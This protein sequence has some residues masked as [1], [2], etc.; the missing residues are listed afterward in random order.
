MKTKKLRFLSVLLTVAMLFALLPT[1]AF[2]EN[3]PATRGSCGEN[4]TWELVG[5]TL[6]ISGT[7][8]MA[9]YGYDYDSNNTIE[10]PWPKTI[11]KV[12]VENGVTT[13][14]KK[15]FELCSSLT[16]VDMSNAVDL[17]TI[18]ENAFADCPELKTVELPQN[19]KLETIGWNAFS[20]YNFSSSNWAASIEK[21]VIPASVTNIAEYAFDGCSKLTTVIFAEGSK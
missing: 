18:G 11:T 10:A 6:T 12:V 2:A 17:I 4:L 5:D 7:G 21:I 3:A 8:A 15:A 14:G 16:E 13:I 1:A 20:Y 19:G 9:D